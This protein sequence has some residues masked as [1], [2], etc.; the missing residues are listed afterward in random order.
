MEENFWEIYCAKVS[1]N[2]SNIMEKKNLKQEDVVE[3][4]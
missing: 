3:L 1:E 2:I 4:W